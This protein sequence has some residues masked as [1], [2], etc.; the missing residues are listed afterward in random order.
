MGGG[1]ISWWWVIGGGRQG[2]VPT[3]EEALMMSSD[4]PGEAAA[5]YSPESPWR[6]PPA[7]PPAVI[8]DIFICLLSPWRRLN[9]ATIIVNH[10]GN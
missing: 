1:G 4:R 8:Y 3:T 5:D 2:F 7:C 9:Y 10:G 6:L